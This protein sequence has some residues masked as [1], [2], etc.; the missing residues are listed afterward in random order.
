LERG[1]GM[2]ESQ[3]LTVRE[4]MT[5]EIISRAKHDKEFKQLLLENPKEA[6]KQVGLNVPDHVDLRVVQETGNV[7]YIVLPAN[8]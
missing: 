6:V 4:I 2:A 5:K 1:T 8:C 3:K 7:C